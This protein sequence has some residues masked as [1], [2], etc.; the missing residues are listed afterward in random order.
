MSKAAVAVHHEHPKE[1]GSGMA[2]SVGL[3]VGE[4]RYKDR[5]K[6]SQHVMVLVGEVKQ[7]TVAPQM[8]LQIADRNLPV[9]GVEQYEGTQQYGLFVLAP[10][11]ENHV[12][13]ELVEGRTFFV[14]QN[15]PIAKSQEQSTFHE[16]ALLTEQTLAGVVD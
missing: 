12:M 8:H 13:Q 4:F 6:L 5:F 3:A 11:V 1:R 16:Q 7:G 14:I 2:T 9:I 15:V 10:L